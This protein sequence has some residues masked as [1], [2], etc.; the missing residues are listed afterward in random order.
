MSF[1][2]PFLNKTKATAAAPPSGGDAPRPEWVT[3]EQR[4]AAAHAPHPQRNNFV[5]FFRNLGET[6]KDFPLDVKQHVKNEVLKVVSNAREF[7]LSNTS[8]EQLFVVQDI[9]AEPFESQ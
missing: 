7:V 6:V 1:V 3:C 4:G 9:K 2:K 5:E 8:V